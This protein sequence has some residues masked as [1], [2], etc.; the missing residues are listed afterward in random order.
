MSYD[1]GY[2][3]KYT[4]RYANH[5]AKGIS[6]FIYH[7]CL[8]LNART[9]CEIGCNVG[10]NLESFPKK[11]EVCGSDRNARAIT[12]ARKKN[13]T[14]NFIQEDIKKSGFKD[15]QFDL[16]FTRGL[17]IHLTVDE[18]GVAIRQMIRMSKK[19]IFNLEYHGKDGQIIPYKQGVVGL[20]RRN[21]AQYYKYLPV[22]ILSE[23]DIPKEID[24]DRV[25]FTLVRIK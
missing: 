14:F 12:L 17:M 24:S 20:W 2:W 5:S 4:D 15:N 9:V 7:T 6:D 3:T 23:V 8:A 11:Y 16:V 19:Y 10:N 25:R 21:M 18:V 13:P 22:T 1:A